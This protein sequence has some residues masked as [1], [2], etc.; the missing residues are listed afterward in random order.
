LRVGWVKF[1]ISQERKNPQRVQIEV[2]AAADA[3]EPDT[4]MYSF[5]PN[6]TT[7]NSV[8]WLTGLSGAGK[9][10]IAWGLRDRL[11]AADQP[12]IVL[13]GDQVR[14][15]LN[16][17]LGFSKMDR[18]ENIRR[19]SEMAQL[20]SN[21]GQCVIV[22]AITPLTEYRTLARE[23]LRDRYCEIHVDAPLALCEQRD[24]KGLYQLARRGQVDQFTG[25][26]DVYEPPLAPALRV[27]TAR[28]TVEE[29]I[30]RVMALMT[31]HTR[32]VPNE[33]AS[34]VEVAW[35]SR[36]SPSGPH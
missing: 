15:G 16:S 22:A 19:I 35:T 30:N 14:N 12:V 10:T 17:D 26:T 34:S 24:V 5:Q 28:C 2:S 6:S 23:I 11:C 36:H 25:V 31:P 27:D 8:I 20:L 9:S 1:D 29:A 4:L 13:D 32:S 21:Q 18:R 3:K 33:Q 7:C